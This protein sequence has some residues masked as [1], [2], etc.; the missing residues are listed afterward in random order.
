MKIRIERKQFCGVCIFQEHLLIFTA[1][2]S[3]LCDRPLINE[4]K[5]ILNDLT[6]MI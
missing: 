3:L 2:S 1:P 4:K 5:T 6:Y